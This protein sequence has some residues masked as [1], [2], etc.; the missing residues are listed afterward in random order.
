MCKLSSHRQTHYKQNLSAS[1]FRNAFNHNETMQRI[2]KPNRRYHTNPNKAFC[3]PISHSLHNNPFRCRRIIPDDTQYVVVFFVFTNAQ[4][5]S[6]CS[7]TFC[8]KVK[9]HRLLSRV[10]NH[11]T[12]ARRPQHN[13]TIFTSLVGQKH[14]INQFV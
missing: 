11:P 3:Q 9:P 8:L 14:K 10:N 7:H 2:D 1:N 12:Y 5:A 6:I 4:K 13:A